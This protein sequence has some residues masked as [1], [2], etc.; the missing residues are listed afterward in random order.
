[1]QAGI[2][3][4]RSFVL[5]ESRETNSKFTGDIVIVSVCMGMG[6]ICVCVSVYMCV[7]VFKWMLA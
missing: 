1:M 6:N 2:L 5:L 4:R 3:V 7:S